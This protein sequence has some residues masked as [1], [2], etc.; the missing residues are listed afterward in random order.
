MNKQLNE[1]Q[2]LINQ[3]N[4]ADCIPKLNSALKT[5]PTVEAFKL[6][7]APK[8][9]KCLS[10]SKASKEAIKFC[11]EALETIP[12]DEEVL[13]DRAEAYLVEEEYEKAIQV[14]YFLISIFLP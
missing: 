8:K 11:S 13:I 3:N 6:K 4:F 2:E 12:D 10:K 5:E 1:A 9:C 14:Y 7:V